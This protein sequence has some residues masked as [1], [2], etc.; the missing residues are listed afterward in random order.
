ML[1]Q[2]GGGDEKNGEEK[3][4]TWLRWSWAASEISGFSPCFGEVHRAAPLPPPPPE[5]KAN[6]VVI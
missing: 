2:G 5:N 4:Y 3:N 6:D 1:V